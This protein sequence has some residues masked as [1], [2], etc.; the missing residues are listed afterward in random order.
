[1]YGCCGTRFKDV[2]KMKDYKNSREWR[3]SNGSV[4]VADT[5]DSAISELEKIS[6]KQFW[7][8]ETND[9]VW[10]VQLR[11]RVIVPQINASTV[12]EA[13]RIARWKAHLD[14]SF[15]RLIS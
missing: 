8:S 9:K 4:V 10:D 5:F 1:M 12:M 6:S 3:F 15:K 11:D 7:A 13:V 2:D 14:K